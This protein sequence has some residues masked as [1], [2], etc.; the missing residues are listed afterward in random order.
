M[1]KQFLMSFLTSYIVC[2]S[3][4]GLMTKTTRLTFGSYLSDGPYEISYSQVIEKMDNRE[5]MLVASY[6][7]SI[8]S[9]ECQTIF[10]DVLKDFIK[11]T[12]YNVYLFNSREM[13]ESQDSY[14][15]INPGYSSPI[16]YIINKGKVSTTFRYSQKANEKLFMNKSELI[17]KVN[18]L[19]ERP[20]YFYVDDKYL[21]ENLSKQDKVGLCIIRNSCSD[22]KYLIPNFMIP[23]TQNF[24]LD[25]EVW[26]LD[27]DKYKDTDE[28]QSIKDKYQ[29]SNSSNSKFGYGDGVVPTTQYYENGSLVDATVY[30]NDKLQLDSTTGNY[31]IIETYYTAERIK[32]LSYL[33]DSYILENKEIEKEEV[34]SNYW[35]PLYASNVHNKIIEKFYEKYFR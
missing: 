4:C 20:C 16:L 12:N 14:N 17:K 6:F 13:N 28:Y 30:F 25:T 21:D 11:E 19:V 29:L 33:D 3:G 8:G 24:Y 10:N 1:K 34:M 31:K 7:G 35:L 5:S 32:N 9:C 2:L 27:I 15:L 22:C 26:V 23:Y 18:R